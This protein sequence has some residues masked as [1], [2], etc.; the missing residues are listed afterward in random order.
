MFVPKPHGGLR[1]VINYIPLNEC[2]IPLR[3]DP[4]LL[5]QMT[6]EIAIHS[7]FTKIDLKNAFYHIELAE[8]SRYLTAFNTPMGTFEY[9]VLP[10]GWCNAPAHLQRAVSWVLRRHLHKRC[11]VFM[12][13]I[14]I[15]SDSLSDAYVHERLILRDLKAANL[16]INVPKCVSRVS[17][18]TFLNLKF[19]AGLIQPTV[20]RDTIA[21]W[22]RPTSKI[23]LQQFLGTANYYRD[24]IPNFSS[25]ASPLYECVGTKWSWQ[26]SQD[27]SFQQLRQQLLHLVSRAPHNPSCPQK[28]ITDASLTGLGVIL[29]ENG[30]PIR[31]ISRKLT[32]AERNYDTTERELLAVVWGLEKLY[33]VL[34]TTHKIQIHTD[35]ANLLRH[36]KPSESHRRR[37]RWIEFL[38]RFSLQWEFIPGAG[39][40]ADGPSRV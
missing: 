28:L 13:D 3:F 33:L 23:A 27:Q 4:P 14:I 6:D 29:E 22:P 20:A 35:H 21:S 9:N 8:E 37:N 19:S 25:I 39:N 38:C 10:M 30:R 12:D 11:F 2:T 36:L 7:F 1:L 26:A 32:P 17:S 40:P 5:D 16:T 34:N 15:F 31:I 24:F 18:I